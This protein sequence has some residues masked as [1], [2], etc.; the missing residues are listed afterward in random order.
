MKEDICYH[1]AVPQDY[2]TNIFT[3]GQYHRNTTR[4]LPQLGQYLLHVCVTT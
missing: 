4:L 3:T 1:R 2:H